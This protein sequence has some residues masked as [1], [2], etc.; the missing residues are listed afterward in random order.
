MNKETD[1]EKLLRLQ[2]ES[3]EKLKG[4]LDELETKSPIEILGLGLALTKLATEVIDLGQRELIHP[5][6]SPDE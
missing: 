4:Y 2:A 3:Y 5:S 1:V 6:E